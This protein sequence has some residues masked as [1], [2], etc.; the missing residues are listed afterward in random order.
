MRAVKFIDDFYVKESFEKLHQKVKKLI[1]K[2]E[3]SKRGLDR[4]YEE[5]KELIEDSGWDQKE[6]EHRELIFDLRSL[7]KSLKKVNFKNPW[8]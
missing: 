8:K 7:A 6:Y 1:S 4:F 2:I 5:K 3:P